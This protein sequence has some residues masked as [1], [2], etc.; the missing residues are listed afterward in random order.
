[1]KI[2]YIYIYKTLWKVSKNTKIYTHALNI[3]DKNLETL[4]YDTMFQRHAWWKSLY[5]GSNRL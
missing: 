1:M 4:I 5:T 2:E 3:S